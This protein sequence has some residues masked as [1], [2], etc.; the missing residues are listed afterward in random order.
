MSTSR[1][2]PLDLVRAFME[3]MAGKH[4]DTAPRWTVDDREYAEAPVFEGRG[5]VACRPATGLRTFSHRGRLAT[6]RPAGPRRTNRPF[7]TGLAQGA[8]AFAVVVLPAAANADTPQA[9]TVIDRGNVDQYAEFFG[10]AMLWSINRGVKINVGPYEKIE[11][12]QP[13]LEA[14]EKYSGQVR[15][16]A[17]RLRLENYIAGLPF[18]AIAADDPDRAIK[19]ILN[20]EAAIEADDLDARNFDCDTGVVGRDGAPVKVERHFLIE[21][22]RRLYFTGRLEVDPKPTMMPNRDSVRYKESLYPL[23]EP[24]DLKGTGFT[25][26]RYLDSSKQDDSWLYL[27]QLRRVRRLSSAQR[28][29]ALFGQD[30]DQDSFGGYAGNVAWMGW[31][32]LGEKT[33]LSSFHARH[34]PVVW[35]DASGDF[36]HADTWEPRK[37]WM[38]EGTSKLPQ[39][40]YLK[41]VMYLDQETNLIAYS[42]IYDTAGELWKMWVNEFKISKKPR[43]EATYES[44]HARRFFPSITMVDIQLEHATYCSLPSSRFPG[45]QG[46][47]V[48]VGDKEGTVE[49]QFELSAII[50][51]GR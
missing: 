22:F 8:V 44:P 37:V 18:P 17:D 25:Y 41:R 36:M 32:Y 27:P 5:P 15:L 28:S 12:A 48:N 20:Y 23:I 29:D 47:Y 9:G 3:A 1:P 50:A 24:F 33:V 38:I 2:T 13:L 14:T 16:G 21:H 34:L 4:R 26:N 45:E 39:Y 7:V 35:G 19:H 46:W 6:A 43:D 30:T 11:Q 31:K 51:A 40:A 49:A 42:D 10:P